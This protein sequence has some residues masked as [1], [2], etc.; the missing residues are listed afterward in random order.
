MIGPVQ[1]FQ[2]YLSSVPASIGVF[3]DIENCSIPFHKSALGFVQKIRDRFFVSRKEAEFMCVCDTSNQNRDTIQELNDAQV[4]IS[5]NFYV[6]I[7]FC[8]YG[9][10]FTLFFKL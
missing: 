4:Y 1:L 8:A 7:V 10:I 2:P 5:V 3:W 6:V 9:F